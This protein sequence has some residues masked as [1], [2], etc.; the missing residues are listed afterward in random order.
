M[1]PRF[2]ILHKGEMHQV[3]AFGELIVAVA[4]AVVHQTPAVTNKGEDAGT[5]H[6]VLRSLTESIVQ[7]PCFWLM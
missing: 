7:F 5:L 1:P 2:G 3:I 6:I 4:V